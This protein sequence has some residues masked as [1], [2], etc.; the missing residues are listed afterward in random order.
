MDLTMAGLGRCG[1]RPPQV[2]IDFVHGLEGVVL[3]D[4]LRNFV[5]QIFQ[6]VELRRIS[7][8]HVEY[9]IVGNLEILALVIVGLRTAG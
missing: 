4:F 3:E 7:W 6:G 5:P 1:V 9:D 8:E 2:L